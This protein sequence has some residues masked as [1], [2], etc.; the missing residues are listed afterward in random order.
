MAAIAVR[1]SVSSWMRSSCSDWS[2]DE[3]YLVIAAARAL[4]FVERKVG[5]EDEVVDRR[6]VDR[7]EGAAD[8]HADADLGLVDHVGLG[9][10]LDDAVGKAFDLEPRL[11][12]GDDDGE[13][14][15]A[16]APDMAVAADFV[17][18]PLGDRLEHGVALGMAEG[19]VDRLEPVEVEEHDRAR[20]IAR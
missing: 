17:A 16:H 8:R 9:D 6:A 12:V 10:R 18:Q 1:R 11:R 15:A 7:A 3:K 2:A 4:G 13:F 19:V 14:V 5:L 20:H